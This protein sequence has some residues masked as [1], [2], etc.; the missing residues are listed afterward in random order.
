MLRLEAVS[1]MASFATLHA[2]L[3]I[4]AFLLLRQ[5]SICYFTKKVSSYLLSNASKGWNA[6][7]RLGAMI[8]FH[9]H[10]ANC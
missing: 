9:A 1:V 7:C 4:N 6:I 5:A 10:S 2:S 3:I 8:K